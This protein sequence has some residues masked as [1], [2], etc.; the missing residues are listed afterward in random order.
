MDEIVNLL[1]VTFQAKSQEEIDGANEA[2]NNFGMSQDFIN[3][4]FSIILNKELSI[5]VRTSAASFLCVKCDKEHDKIPPE[6]IDL[7][8][9]QFPQLLFQVEP[10]LYN[11]FRKFSY[12]LSNKFYI[13]MIQSN[14]I[15]LQF[16][17]FLQ[18]PHIMQPASILFKYFTKATQDDA[19]KKNFL[20]ANSLEVIF[21]VIQN[22]N[23]LY[24]IGNLI[25]S[26]RYLLNN[27]IENSVYD[28]ISTAFDYLIALLQNKESEYYS[29]FVGHFIFFVY[30]FLYFAQE[31]NYPNFK[32]LF[33]KIVLTTH[34]LNDSSVN[35]KFIQLLQVK[36][37]IWDS[38]IQEEENI[39]YILENI[40]IPLFALSEEA[41]SK[42][43]SDP[44]QFCIENIYA[45]GDLKDQYSRAYWCITILHPL[46]LPYIIPYAQTA[47]ENYAANK[48]PCALYSAL[49][50]C[51][52]AWAKLYKTIEFSEKAIEFLRDT[53]VLLNED[54]LLP[55]CGFI[56]LLG[57]IDD[58]KPLPAG[59]P[60]ELI[61][62]V[63]L[64]CDQDNLILQYFSC[65]S[66]INLLDSIA[67]EPGTTAEFEG[68][69]D[70]DTSQ[71]ISMVMAISSEFN[72]IAFMRI[73][74]ACIRMPGFL[75]AI[76]PVATEIVLDYFNNAKG[77]LLNTK[78]E[79]AGKMELIFN[80][81]MNLID[82][83]KA[84]P[85]A[86]NEILAV[87]AAQ[88]FE[89][90]DFFDND[91][92]LEPALDLSC[93]I[94]GL[95]SK[96][97]QEF[98]SLVQVIANK[99]GEQKLS[100]DQMSKFSIMLNNLAVLDPE[101]AL[102]QM[103]F[104][105]QLFQIISAMMSQ[106]ESYVESFSNMAAAILFLSPQDSELHQEIMS[107]IAG[108]IN[109]KVDELEDDG[110]AFDFFEEMENIIFAFLALYPEEAL[111]L[112]GEE[113]MDILMTSY[114]GCAP[115]PIEPLYVIKCLGPFLHK[116]DIF[117]YL[118]SAVPGFSPEN[119]TK[120]INYND[121]DIEAMK[122]SIETVPL[123]PDSTRLPA[124]VEFLK[125]IIS[126]DSEAAEEMEVTELLAG[127][128]KATD[129]EQSEDTEEN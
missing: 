72:D 58:L 101:S 61:H 37:S 65:Y 33:E 92:T 106:N 41:Q 97:C 110:S 43:E 7:I 73:I 8:I 118:A 89:N 94:I 54:S 105:H 55:R 103:E 78:K 95:S 59:F 108:I 128:Q 122:I 1:S 62:E 113:L 6:S 86:L 13:N 99:L 49:H 56:L 30:R 12:V 123:I 120:P 52:A 87:S 15:H 115:R 10:A 104:F 119:I 44:N 70:F 53:A 17:D 129:N 76:S 31:P 51:S 45:G 50:F 14:N 20:L 74:T 83:M 60:I 46:I 90:V 111:S 24:F 40:L 39:K 71:F 21:Q 68:M 48:D 36:S 84:V 100:V 23:D 4:L 80:P 11:Y 32:A 22:T 98:W 2:L 47:V 102:S 35:Y 27:E 67:R 96:S 26:I 9:S 107:N 63:I 18:N 64:Q 77:M 91:A 116:E 57:S 127:L 29:K 88:L 79:D 66:L 69:V 5:S 82:S 114:S 121:H 28:T 117:K 42:I 112:L 75:T 85:E 81:V 125:Q 19:E 34:E 109:E 16:L 93:Q 38:F 3:I 124:V 126:I 25:D